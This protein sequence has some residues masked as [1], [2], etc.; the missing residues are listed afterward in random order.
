MRRRAVLA[1]S[2]LSY[3]LSCRHG[4]RSITREAD[5]QTAWARNLAAAVPLGLSADSARQVMLRNGFTCVTGADSVAY[6]WCDKYSGGESE[7]VRQRWQA[8]LNLDDRGRV[9]EA[10]AFYGLV[11]L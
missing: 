4:D 8:N 7:L 5:S 2:I 1:L 3:P 10:R 6:L 11:G 9:Y